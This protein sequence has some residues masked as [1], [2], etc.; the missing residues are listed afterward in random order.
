M[1]LDYSGVFVVAVIYW[2]ALL[3]LF[4]WLSRRLAALRAKIES[5][6]ERGR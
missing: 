2:T 4:L 3:V 1:E 5:L 6:E